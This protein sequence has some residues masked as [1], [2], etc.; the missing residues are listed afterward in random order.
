ML[1]E[2]Q[3]G[4][5]SNGYAWGDLA[6][7][8]SLANSF[9]E[10]GIVNSLKNNVV[11]SGESLKYP[12]LM[13]FFSGIL[14]KLGITIQNS[15]IF[16][17]LVFILLFISFLYFLT[18]KITKSK[19]ASFLAPFFFFFNGS[20]F[21]L[22]KFFVDFSEKKGNFFN[23]L[24]N[25]NKDYSSLKGEIDFGNII[26]HFI[27]PQ[28]AIIL[29]L[30]LGTI[31]I[32]FLWQYWEKRDKK[33]LLYSGI[34]LGLLPLSHTHTFLSLSLVVFFLFLIDIFFNRKN[35]KNIFENWANLIAPALIL[36]LPQILILFPF[37]SKGFFRINFGWM[38]EEE[39]ILWF[40][41]K[42]FG[43]HWIILFLGFILLKLKEKTFYLPFLFL[44]IIGNIFVFQPNIWDNSKIFIW[45]FLMSSILISHFFGIIWKKWKRKSIFLIIP[46]FLILISVGFLSVRN[47]QIPS[48]K[49]FDKN[50]I[51]LSKFIKENTEKNSLF[52]TFD[53]HNNPIHCLAGRRVLM[54]YR[55]WLWT[56]GIDYKQREK[57]IY[58]ILNG[59][60]SLELIEKYDIEYI[61]IDEM[62]K[63]NFKVNK[64]YFLNNQENFSK[65]FENE[66]YLVFEFKE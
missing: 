60:N 19:L 18:L 53:N 43:F 61:V 35:W 4:L 49:L 37:S 64:E 48:W 23:F 59:I 52:L 39:N 2:K 44:F 1:K 11:Y 22:Y 21:G 50:D 66:R 38:K 45:W 6:L 47:N 8:I 46:V 10:R 20:V 42:N 40:W 30:L 25:L 41:I 32:Y 55:G 15:L 29:G 34:F 63:R 5:Y 3:D 51:E 14:I 65:I 12:F 13:D 56:H 16:P 31:L 57:D 27:L 9:A 58:S 26:T 7:H 17:S 33:F 24:F 62:N 54:G 28:R 36:S